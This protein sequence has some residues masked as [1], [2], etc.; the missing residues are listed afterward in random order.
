MTGPVPGFAVPAPPQFRTVPGQTGITVYAWKMPIAFGIGVKIRV[1]G[2]PVPNAQWGANFVPGPPGVH[3][4]TVDSTQLG[5]E[6][7]G[8][9]VALQVFPGYATEVHYTAPANTFAKGVL[10]PERRSAPGQVLGYIGMAVCVL[11]LAF[12]VYRLVS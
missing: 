6:Y 11:L 9:A 1:N 8:G 3:T 4:V 7:G 12:S 5:M 2:Y 10:T